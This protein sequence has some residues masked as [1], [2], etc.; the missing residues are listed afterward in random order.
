MQRFTHGLPQ[1][2]F[3]EALGEFLTS[4][5]VDPFGSLLLLPTPALVRQARRRMAGSGLG[6]ASSSVD[7]LEGFAS[8]ILEDHGAGSML[9]D[10]MEST[11]LL[12]QVLMAG[13]KDLPMLFR[14][15]EIR[16]GFLHDLL[17]FLAT[18]DDYGIGP[19]QLK[20]CG[21]RG[22]Q[23]SRVLKD[24]KDKEAGSG[25][26]SRSGLL[27]MAGQLIEERRPSF[28]KCVSFGLYE[29]TPAQTSLLTA[30][31]TACQDAHH[32]VPYLDDDKLFSTPRTL[33]GE[34]PIEVRE[35]RGGPDGNV[36]A[37]PL[38]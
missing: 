36:Q 37:F 11:V 16:E 29:P 38:R 35:P 12:R 5:S 1:E 19:E 28:S 17:T 18:C 10:E 20:A 14:K 32:F 34:R 26:F 13:R 23:L 21:D 30:L 9:L 7:T 6:V 22:A 8:Q 33:G 27:A 25:G 15:G 24:Y 31:M 3:E 2:M 4:Y